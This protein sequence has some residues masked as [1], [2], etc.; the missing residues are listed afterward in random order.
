MTLYLSVSEAAG[1][2]SL[3]RLVGRSFGALPC[4]PMRELVNAAVRQQADKLPI[5]RA[6][7]TKNHLRVSVVSL[8]IER[9]IHPFKSPHIVRSEIACSEQI[10]QGDFRRQL[11]A[12]C[13]LVAWERLQR[14]DKP[15]CIPEWRVFALPI[16]RS[17]RTDDHHKGNSCAGYGQKTPG[18]HI[19]ANAR[20][21][22]WRAERVRSVTEAE[23]RH[24]VQCACWA[25]YLS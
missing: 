9:H 23:S 8:R 24:P 22:W 1:S 6:G 13:G 25:A 17:S 10:L 14:T 5:R 15:R 18:I 2:R 12:A 19:T 7:A 20:T 4:I 16:G 11:L 21:H 3:N